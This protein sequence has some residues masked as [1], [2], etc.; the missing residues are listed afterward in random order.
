[1]AKRIGNTV[2][3]Y[4]RLKSSMSWRLATILWPFVSAAFPTNC[5]KEGSIGRENLSAESLEGVVILH[6]REKSSHFQLFAHL[7]Y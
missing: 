6:I 4:F 5:I 1:M 2:K 7:I 3:D